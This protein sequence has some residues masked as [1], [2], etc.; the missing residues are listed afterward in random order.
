MALSGHVVLKGP[1]RLRLQPFSQI[2][3]LVVSVIGISCACKRASFVHG[4]SALGAG[5]A[6]RLGVGCEQKAHHFTSQR[7]PPTSQRGSGSQGDLIFCL[8]CAASLCALSVRALHRPSQQSDAWRMKARCRRVRCTACFSGSAARVP[9]Y[10]QASAALSSISMHALGSEP[11]LLQSKSL[12]TDDFTTSEGPHVAAVKQP[13]VI[14]RPCE[15][16]LD[17]LA[18][19]AGSIPACL[20]NRL[21]TALRVQK[22]WRSHRRAERARRRSTGSEHAARRRAGAKLQKASNVLSECLPDSY[23]S[24]RLRTKIQAGLQTSAGGN[25]ERGR[26][27]KGPSASTG[28]TS[29]PVAC[30]RGCLLHCLRSEHNQEHGHHLSHRALDS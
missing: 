21:R 27:Q 24:S 25:C 22:A 1:A 17:S 10:P 14:E 12:C 11:Q 2:K 13:L 30:V 3:L 9:A 23:D 4:P 28:T 26:E 8:A 20:V 16:R 15:Q 19:V 29:S 6:L 7:K 18:E 5:A